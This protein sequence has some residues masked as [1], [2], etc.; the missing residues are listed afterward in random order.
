MRVA[1]N[2]T[3]CHRRGGVERVLVEC[4]NFLAKRGHLTHVFAAE[5]DANVLNATVEK[6]LV[7]VSSRVALKRLLKF[8]HAAQERIAEL[9]PQPDVLA[10][11]GV[12]GPPNAVGWR[13]AISIAVWVAVSSRK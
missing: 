3:S 8:S 9:D 12:V 6:H 1:L 4:A 10:G 2:F 13:S 5:I 7:P 11:F